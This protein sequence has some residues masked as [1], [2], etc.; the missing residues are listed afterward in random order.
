MKGVIYTVF[1]FFHFHFRRSSYI[2]DSHS[3]CQFG[4]AFLEFFL[5]IV[6]SSNFNLGFDLSYTGFYLFALTSSIYDSGVVLV[7]SYTF[8]TAK[9]VNSSIFKGKASFFSYDSTTC[10]DSDV[11]KHGFATVSKTRSFYSSNTKGTTQF[12][13]YQGS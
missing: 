8:G 12:V 1:L 11:L 9:H 3:T 2:E 7:N 10:K 4:Q 5:V 13:H 6:R